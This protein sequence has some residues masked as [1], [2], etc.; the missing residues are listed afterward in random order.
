MT[1]ID[2]ARLYD[3]STRF[4]QC[5]PLTKDDLQFLHDS[6]S[7][8]LSITAHI[9]LKYNLTSMELRRDLD[10]VERCLEE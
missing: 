9:G 4:R 1:E 10:Q 5:K 8:A 2:T 3:V 7:V 6:I